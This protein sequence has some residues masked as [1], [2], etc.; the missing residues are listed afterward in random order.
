M[1]IQQRISELKQLQQ[2]EANSNFINGDLWNELDDMIWRLEN[3]GQEEPLE[4]ILN[5][6]G[7][8]VG[9]RYKDGSEVWYEGM[10]FENQY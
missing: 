8:V 9:V 10:T 7:W 5:E 4:D 1:N 3:Y 2:I 6:E